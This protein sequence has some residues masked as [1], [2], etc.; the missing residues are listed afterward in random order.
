[1]LKKRV[2]IAL[3]FNKGVLY[4]TRNFVPNNIYT[5][6]F[7]DT[8]SVDEIVMLD[9]S[10]EDENKQEFEDF[11]TVVRKISKNCFVP[12]SVGGRVA[13]IEDAE[14]YLKNGADKIV[15]NSNA[16][17][18]PGLITEIAQK[19]GSQCVV[20]SIDVKKLDNEYVVFIN[21]GK[22][23]TGTNLVEWI[24]KA[25][26]YGAGEIFLNSIDKDGML[27]GYDLEMIKTSSC[28]INIPLVVCGGAGSW[29]HFADAF[30]CG[31]DAACTTNIF[32][33]T[34][35]SI[36]SAK[37]YLKNKKVEVRE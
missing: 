18:N 3:L 35:S 4:R 8:W 31:A 5:H 27:D 10:R 29:Q 30:N 20:V 1:M 21:D 34:E 28:K 12:L 19:Y 11:L 13:S 17:A 24:Q 37:Q 22:T 33:F 6:N 16:F 32:H 14:K 9:I 23:N 26:Q 15:I 25:E 7:I 2:V 36:K